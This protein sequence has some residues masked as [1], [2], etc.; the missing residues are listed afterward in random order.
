MKKF[1]LLLLVFA[2]L[3]SFAQKKRIIE[4]GTWKI[5]GQFSLNH[6]KTKS[7]VDLQNNNDN[8]N[9]HWLVMPQIS[10]AISKN[11][12]VGLKIG[13]KHSNRKQNNNNEYK[14][15]LYTLGINLDKY[16]AINKQLLFNLST[17]INYSWADQTD[18]RRQKTLFIGF[19]PELNFFLSKR[20][21]IE[22]SIG[23]LGYSFYKSNDSGIDHLEAHSFQ[24]NLN[25]EDLRFGFAYYF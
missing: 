8:K 9:Y 6:R 16:F 25:S 20:F 24:M 18:D 1:T 3:N 23:S 11:T 21:A 7:N 14:N 22:A 5:G 19:Q 13:Y 2:S 4:K 17:N 15:D 12:L 10:Y